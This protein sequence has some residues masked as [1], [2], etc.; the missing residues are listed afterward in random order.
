MCSS[1]GVVFRL[2]DG[3]P[4]Q[5]WF[6]NDQ[7]ACLESRLLSISLKCPT[8]SIQVGPKNLGMNVSD[9]C[10]VSFKDHT[11]RKICLKPPFQV[12]HVSP[13]SNPS[14]S[15]CFSLTL[16]ISV[17]GRPGPSTALTG[18]A[19][20][21]GRCRVPSSSGVWCGCLPTH[22]LSGA[23]NPLVLCVRVWWGVC[24]CGWVCV[25]G[26]CACVCVGGCM[27]IYKT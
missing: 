8:Q 3:L 20:S 19:H 14:H 6:S 2:T 15:L 27:N 7:Q 18:D 23:C 12:C 13:K 11:S 4:V 10:T 1:L 26:V 22:S 24:V 17:A 21:P 25:G 9:D 5:P 16:S